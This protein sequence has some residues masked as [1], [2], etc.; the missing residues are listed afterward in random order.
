MPPLVD[1][2]LYLLPR[3][4]RSHAV[5]EEAATDII[6]LER[7]EWEHIYQRQVFFIDHLGYMEPTPARRISFAEALQFERLHE[8]TYA[9]FGYDCLHIASASLAE[10]VRSILSRC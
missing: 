4:I 10:R 9:L 6:A 7:M 1:T 5:V 3:W 2:T 8:D